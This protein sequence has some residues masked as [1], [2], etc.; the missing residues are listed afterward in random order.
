MGQLTIL[1]KDLKAKGCRGLACMYVVCCVGMDIG[2][3]VRC[4]WCDLNSSG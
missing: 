4:L 1:K 2:V 3:V